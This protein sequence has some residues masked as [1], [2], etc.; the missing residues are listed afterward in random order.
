V[1]RVQSSRFGANISS[2]GNIVQFVTT[3]VLLGEYRPDFTDDEVELRVRYPLD[4]RN[5]SELETLRLPTAYG[6][7]PLSNF[8]TWNA[9]PKVGFLERVDSKRAITVKAAVK[10]G[11]L[12]DNQVK[13][14][15]QWINKEASLNPQV[16]VEFKGEDEEQ[17]EA[18]TFLLRAF[19][20]ALAIMAIILVAQFNNFYY[21]FL[22]L[23]AVIFSTVG[24]FLGLLITNHAFSIV[25]NGIGVVALAGIVVN[26]N[27]ILIDTY[28]GLKRHG[29]DPFDAVLRTAA[30]RLRPVLLTT[31][32][33]V[34]GLIPMVIGLNIDFIAREITFGAPSTQW[35]KQLSVSIAFGLAFATVLTLVLTPAMLV[36]GER[37]RAKPKD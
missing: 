14:L 36:L 1:D 20:V 11:Y 13:Q 2:V 33:T 3:G 35:W 8:V 7:I 28:A 22:I 18:Q 17:Q 34:L 37:K 21:A 9:A 26:N 30:Q 23:T 15:R 27:I 12:A 24:V 32:T 10:D 16:N 19:L 4:Y 29:L 31:V 6:L 25:M 5:I